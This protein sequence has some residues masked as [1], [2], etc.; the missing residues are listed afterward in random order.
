M[1][2]FG[3]GILGDEWEDGGEFFACA[4]GG[5]APAITYGCPG[6]DI[7]LGQNKQKKVNKKRQLPVKGYLSGLGCRSEA[8]RPCVCGG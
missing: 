7:E 3:S 2:A 8:L 6:L 1:E 5:S 4:E